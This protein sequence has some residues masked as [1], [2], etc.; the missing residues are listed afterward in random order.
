M[1]FMPHQQA[2]ST[3]HW[4]NLSSKIAPFE[5]L[6]LF[7]TDRNDRMINFVWFFYLFSS[8]CEWAVL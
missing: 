7:D 6:L 3:A 1:K 4:N 2:G 5:P 8:D